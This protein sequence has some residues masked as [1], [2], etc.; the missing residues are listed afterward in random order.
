[1]ATLNTSLQAPGDNNEK[2]NDPAEVNAKDRASATSK[3]REGERA[4]G[5]TE[6]KASECGPLL[7][8]LTDVRVGM[9]VEAR[10]I[11]EKWYD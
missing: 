2:Q 9:K 7:T 1:M 8:A 10:D 11:Y 3:V 4:D 6:L 5:T